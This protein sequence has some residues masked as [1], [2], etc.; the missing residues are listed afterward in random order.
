MTSNHYH[1]S[2]FPFPWGGAGLH[3]P[4]GSDCARGAVGAR[5]VDG[6][7]VRPGAVHAHREACGNENGGLPRGA[8]GHCAHFGQGGGGEEDG[9]C[10]EWLRGEEEGWKGGGGTWVPVLCV[11]S[12]SEDVDILGFR[13][14]EVWQWRNVCGCP[15]SRPGGEGPSLYV[16]ALYLVIMGST[17]SE[18]CSPGLRRWGCPPP[19]PGLGWDWK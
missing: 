7:S 6:D 19:P 5:G 17:E 15:W 11:E 16:I 12:V 4:R 3:S 9:M 18:V 8:C 13:D 10:C 2:Y 1:Q 14:F